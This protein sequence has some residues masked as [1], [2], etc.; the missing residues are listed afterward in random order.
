MRDLCHA[1]LQQIAQSTGD[2]VFLTIRAGFDGVC[3]DRAEGAFPIKVFVLEVGRRRPINIGGGAIA[4]LSFLEDNEIERILKINKDRCVEKFTNYSEAEVRKTIARARGRGYVVS[5][6]VELP[7]VR[8]IAVPIFDKNNHP[9]AAISVATL[10]TRL[11]K[12]RTELVLDSLN[13]AIAQIQ[14]NLLNIETEN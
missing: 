11:D 3:I 14:P 9:V 8:T 12:D 5:D 6:V 7:G 4:I 10:S 13:K 2:T 1:Q